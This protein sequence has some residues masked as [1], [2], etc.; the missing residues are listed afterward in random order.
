MFLFLYWTFFFF[1]A[2][3]LTWAREVIVDD[4]DPQITYA[5][6]LGPVAD[7][8]QDHICEN[9]RGGLPPETIKAQVVATAHNATWHA[10]RGP[11]RQ[12]N[13]TLDF[14]GSRIAAS[15]IVLK[16]DTSDAQPGSVFACP[17][18]F[19]IDGS[20]AAQ[21]PLSWSELATESG[22]EDALFIPNLVLFNTTVEPG[23]HVFTIDYDCGNSTERDMALALDKITYWTSDEGTVGPVS[24]TSRKPNLAPIIAGSVAGGLAFIALIGCAIF[25]WLKQRRQHPPFDL[26]QSSFGEPPQQANWNRLSDIDELT[27]IS[28]S[29]TSS[30]EVSQIHPRPVSDAL[31]VKTLSTLSIFSRPGADL[32]GLPSP[33]AHYGNRSLRESFSSFSH[34]SYG[35]PWPPRQSHPYTGTRFTAQR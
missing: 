10:A 2:G 27:E 4:T 23:P 3:R 14:E 33:Q 20:L 29:Q 24:A 32:N 19:Y 30:P 8:G 26:A 7:W 21:R 17:L 34:V 25:W 1:A 9:C 13:A 18:S 22:K 12:S 16:R 11:A 31:S 28:N 15:F 5:T 35:Q 6:R